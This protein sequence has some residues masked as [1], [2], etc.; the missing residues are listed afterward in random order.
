M[1]KI[2]EQIK[3][4]LID[5]MVEEVQELVKEAL[6]QGYEARKILDD[7]LLVGMNEVGILFKEGDLFVPEVLMSAKAMNTGVEILKPFLQEK[8][9]EKSGLVLFA[10]VKG[11]LHDIGKKLV[12]IMLEGSGFEVIDLGVDIAPN[13]IVEA[14]QK[15]NPDIVCM[16]AMLTTTMVAMKDTINA[17]KE[18]NLYEKVDIMVGGAPISEKYAQEIGAHY[19]SNASGAVDLANQLIG[20]TKTN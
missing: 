3:E 19:T 10:T 11:D 16:S 17:L 5:G 6:D 15:Y 2:F 13:A 1:I 18:E 4:G 9:M 12:I 14:V 7:G 20:K 8:D